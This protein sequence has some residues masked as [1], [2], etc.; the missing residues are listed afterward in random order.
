MMN[1]F[2]P[3]WARLFSLNVNGKQSCFYQFEQSIHPKCSQY[4]LDPADTPYS[5]NTSDS[6]DAIDS[7]DTANTLHSRRYSTDSNGGPCH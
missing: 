3:R 7:P 1:I 4:S 5:P 6:M 2:F